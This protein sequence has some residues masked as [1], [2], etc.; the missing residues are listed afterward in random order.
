MWAP[1][2]DQQG[3]PNIARTAAREHAEKLDWQTTAQAV[4][5]AGAAPRTLQLLI[6]LANAA[7]RLRG[8]DEPIPGTI[9]RWQLA[10]TLAAKNPHIET[11]GQAEMRADLITMRDPDIANGVMLAGATFTGTG[12]SSAR[13]DHRPPANHPTTRERPTAQHER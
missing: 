11:R 12:N 8:G 1:I 10:A 5:H 7:R 13:A 2:R 4:I 6:D 3:T 9:D